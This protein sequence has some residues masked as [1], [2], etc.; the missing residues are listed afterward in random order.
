M[1]VVSP[2]LWSELVRRTLACY[3]EELL[4]RVAG[5][6]VKPRNFWPAPELISR[7]IDTLDNPPVLDR[8]R[9]E[10]SPAC[11]QGLALIALSRQPTWAVGNL[12]ELLM[13]LG[14][15]DGI[16]VVL[17]LLEGGLLYPVL[18]QVRPGSAPL[19]PPE[20]TRLRSFELWL[21]HPGPGGL[22]VFAPPQILSRAAGEELPVPDLAAAPESAAAVTPPPGLLAQQAD[23]L[24]WLLRLGVLWQ[25]VSAAPL[26]RTQQG[27]FFKRDQERLEEDALLGGP[28]ADRHA[29]VRDLGF[30][31][32]GLA[33][34]EGILIE[35]EGEVR[36]GNLPE[37]W[38]QGLSAALASMWSDLFH[39][40]SWTVLDGWRGGTAPLGGN[41]FPS[42]YLLVFLLLRRLP[43]GAW[44]RPDMIADW[45]QAH[46]PYWQNE[47]L[48]PSRQGPWVESFLLGVAYHLQ[49]VE[50]GRELS[51]DSWVRLSG[52]G[53]WLLGQADEPPGQTLYAQTL[54]V[55]PNLEI[56]AYRQGLSTSLIARLTRFAAWKTLGAACTLQLEPET[57]YRA[58]EAGETFDSIRLALE[59]HGTRATP[60]A[61]LDSLR[62]WANKRDRITV[63]PAATLLEFASAADLNEAL[64]R[65]LAAV[66]IADTL[67]VAPS[68]DAIDFRQFRLTGTRDYTLP[69]EKCVT[70]EPDGVTL[71]VDL[72]RSDLLL[73][74]ELPR[75]AEPI[76]KSSP[77]G[78]K[79]YRLTPASLGAARA[80]GVSLATVETWFQ[81]RT[82]GPITPAARL[83]LTG[84]Q[85]NAPQLKKHLVL[86]VA[87]A[88]LADGLMQWPETRALIE[89]R[90]GPTAVVVR[91]EQVEQLRERL[92][93]AGMEMESEPA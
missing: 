26:R 55:Q 32:A 54:L 86:H 13:A 29:E 57:V 33:E 37:S 25:Q 17:E 83:L 12:V 65:G 38:E 93:A 52:L 81:Q 91:Q 49:L 5:R 66:R 44:V 2:V 80:A 71:T 42:A 4:R 14:H 74:S 48:R 7:S 53:R 23:G 61:V 64:A 43:L 75:F 22:T 78:K 60:A 15:E 40:Q 87:N 90:L 70:V 18:G 31:I 51:G 59:Q 92:R 47:A 36:V 35:E 68:E 58:L 30:L 6:F 79:Q 20:G 16:K 72:S 28:P 21:A 9:E 76:E 85:G 39:L 82:G 11:R 34:L 19:A 10:L 8:R 27:G 69:P 84:A 67:A 63:F 45:L 41:P 46:H 73:E 56:V 77:I 50:L 24:E 1:A 89:S 3:E 62:T 88:D